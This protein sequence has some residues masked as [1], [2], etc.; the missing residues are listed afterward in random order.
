MSIVSMILPKSL[1]IGKFTLI[2]KLKVDTG[3]RKCGMSYMCKT[4]TT[5][6]GTTSSQVEVYPYCKGLTQVHE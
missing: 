5:Q 6:A 4:E 2:S 1:I 3:E